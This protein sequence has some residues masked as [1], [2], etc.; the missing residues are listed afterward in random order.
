MP[1]RL[2]SRNGGAVEPEIP[3]GALVLSGS[4]LAWTFQLDNGDA[5][6]RLGL[7]ALEITTGRAAKLCA[8]TLCTG[9]PEFDNSPFGRLIRADRES[10]HGR[11]RGCGKETG[12]PCHRR[13]Y[14]FKPLSPNEASFMSI[15]HPSKS[16]ARSGSFRGVVA[17]NTTPALSFISWIAPCG[18]LAKSE[19]SSSVP[20]VMPHLRA[21]A[22]H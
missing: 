6:A 4:W 1:H 11:D 15:F 16:A 19:R 13:R 12:V 9:G 7:L 10:Y 22:Q 18:S 14:R 3:L 2:Q 21:S 8:L 17:P 5:V 20:I